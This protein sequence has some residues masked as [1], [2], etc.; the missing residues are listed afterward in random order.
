[1]LCKNIPLTTIIIFMALIFWSCKKNKDDVQP[2]GS[3]DFSLKSED[4]HHDSQPSPTASFVLFSIE[5]VSGERLHTLEKADLAPSDDGYT[6]HSIPLPLG[7]YHLVEFFVLGQNDEVLYASPRSGSELASMVD[8]PLEIQVNL[9][10]GD[11]NT[12]TPEVIAITNYL[13]QD[14]GYNAFGFEEIEVIN[15]SIAAHTFTEN[16]WELAKATFKVEAMAG[17]DEVVWTREA[18]LES[19]INP[20]NMRGGYDQYRFILT[21]EGYE[22]I[23]EIYSLAD[24]RTTENFTFQLNA[25]ATTIRVN[26]GTAVVIDSAHIVMSRQGTRLKKAL[27][28]ENGHGTATFNLAPGDW[29]QEIIVYKQ[30]SNDPTHITSSMISSNSPISLEHNMNLSYEGP[31][32]KSDLDW[33]EWIILKDYETGVYV[34]MDANPE[35]LHVELHLNGR[36]LNYGYVDRFAFLRSDGSICNMVYQECNPAGEP[37]DTFCGKEGDIFGGPEFN[38]CSPGSLIDC[39]VVLALEGIPYDIYFFYVWPRSFDSS[40]IIDR[41]IISPETRKKVAKQFLR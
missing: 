24:L 10:S 18:N 1:M 41:P 4:L 14:F 22:T 39:M 36:I 33:H 17:V 27:V 26:F 2:V 11:E 40:G 13:P 31:F 30:S 37:S 38:T 25:L 9:S 23:E 8:R 35:V 34:K 16:G 19:A 20:I 3:F 5:T 28:L 15:A 6:S 32:T 29:E 12:V 21:K 7:D